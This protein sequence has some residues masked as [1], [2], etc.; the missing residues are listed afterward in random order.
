MVACSTL[1]SCVRL[2]VSDFSSRVAC[3]QAKINA[4]FAE[5]VYDALSS[6]HTLLPFL[7]INPHSANAPLSV[8]PLPL[9][10]D[11]SV[12]EPTNPVYT[13]FITPGMIAIISF[14]QAIGLTAM[15]FVADKRHDLSVEGLHACYSQ[16][17]VFVCGEGKG[18]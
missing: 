2:L 3:L 4:A 12:A 16:R 9:F 17:R 13:D 6:L 18:A 11:P 7:S 10:N 1:I 15:A 5:F 8:V 14:A